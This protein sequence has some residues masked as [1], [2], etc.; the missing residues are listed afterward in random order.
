MANT[1]DRRFECGSVILSIDT[2]Q[3]WGYLDMLSIGSFHCR[4]PGALEMHEKLLRCLCQGNIGA[5]WFVVG[6]MTL[7]ASSGARDP[8]FAGL[9]HD[10]VARIPAGS[11]A[12][13][14]LWYRPSFVDLLSRAQPYQEIGLH[15]GLT[16][17][18]WTAPGATRD[19]AARE[20]GEG[21]RALQQS[22]VL[23][24]SF[25][26]CRECEDFYDLLPAHGIRAYR[27]RTVTLGHRLGATLR[28]VAVRLFD[29]LRRATPPVVFPAETMPG[30][31]NVP[32][33]MFL[34]PISPS[35]TRVTGMRSRLARFR[36]GVE[37]A[38]RHRGLFQYA[39]HPENL[40]EAPGGMSLFEDLIECLAAA[41]DRG[42]VEV[43]TISGLVDRL[44]KTRAVSL[45]ENQSHAT[46]KQ[47]TDSRLSAVDRS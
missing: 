44:E 17:W 29:E 40:T 4:F 10:W 21:I 42:D 41:R 46:R 18:I 20:L 31:W 23:P 32:A 25:S 35:R 33:S 38:A 30:L 43:L 7:P 1:I 15:G 5:T 47:P 27:G 28:G 24:R 13:Q 8:R 14:P 12:T 36:S 6:G 34:Y 11:E 39:F 37:A 3:I 45:E 22:C 9:P 16:H 19:V 2:E 26:F